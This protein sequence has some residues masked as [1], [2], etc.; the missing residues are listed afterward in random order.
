[1]G[2]QLKETGPTIATKCY[3]MEGETNRIGA[4]LQDIIS[5]RYG[6]IREDTAEG[7]P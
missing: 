1:M 2:R 4:V 7:L 6:S 5:N 3:L